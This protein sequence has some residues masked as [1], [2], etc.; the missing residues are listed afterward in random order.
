[1]SEVVSFKQEM[2]IY[3]HSIFVLNIDR[4]LNDLNNFIWQIFDMYL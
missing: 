1:M 4:T 3:I 2:R